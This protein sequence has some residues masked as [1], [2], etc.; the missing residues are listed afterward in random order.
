[1]CSAHFYNIVEI[2]EIALY[3]FFVLLNTQYDILEN[4]GRET[5]LGHFY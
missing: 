1:M 2:A 5:V 4:V 3:V